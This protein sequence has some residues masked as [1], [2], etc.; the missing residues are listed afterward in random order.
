MPASRPVAAFEPISPDFDVKKLVEST[1]S[2]DYVPRVNVDMLNARGASDFERLVRQHVILGGKP[3]VVEGYES[4]LDRWTFALQWLRDNHSARVETARDLTKK[5]NVPLSIGHY[6]NHMAL[7]TNQWNDKNYKEPARQR[8][9][10]KDI[11]CPPL[12]QEKLQDII[13]PNVFYLNESIGDFGGLGSL[14]EA[15]PSG[16]GTRKGRGVAKAADLMS[17]LPKEMRAENLMCYIGHEGT[18]TPAHKEMCASLGQN[19]MVETSTGAIEDGKP[20]KPGSSIWFMTESKE[21]EVVSEYWLSKLGHDIEVENH[22][23]QVNAWRAAPFKTWVVEQRVGDL[24]LIPPLAP[25]QVWN[26]GTRTMKVAW[27]RTTVETLELA[28]H[29][30]LPSAR[31]VCRDEQYKNKAII[32]YTLQKYS[33]QIRI[34]DKQAQK[35]LRRNLASDAYVQNLKNDFRKLQVLFTEILVSESFYSAN[36]MNIPKPQLIPYESFITCSYCR[37]NIFNRF[38]T[39]P[40][41]IAPLPDGEEDTYDICMD[42]YAMGR[43]CAC[44]SKLKW[45]EQWS[46]GELTQNHEKWR[47]HIL[48]IEGKVSEKSPKSLRTELEVLGRHRTLAQVCQSELAHRP[49]NDIKREKVS[50]NLRKGETDEPEIDDNGIV[51]KSKKPRKSE[52]FVREHARC[53]VDCH[54]E[55][56]WKQAECSNCD[57]KY[58]FGLLFRGYDMMPQDILADPA[59]TCP[60]CRNICSCRNCR[61]RPGF[62]PYTPSGTM[63]GHNT[64]AIADPRS[65]ESLVDFGYSNIS[66][67]QKAGD[68]NE[69]DTRRMRK[70]K[71]IADDRANQQD[72]EVDDGYEQVEEDGIDN[73]IL[74]LAQQEGIPIDPALAAMS[75]GQ[76]NTTFNH[77][78]LPAASQADSDEFDENPEQVRGTD[79]GFGDPPA[80]QYVIPSGGVVRDLEHAYDNIEAI[81]YDYPDPEMGMHPPAPMEP[82]AAETGVAPGYEPAIRGNDGDIAMIERKRKRT[83]VDEGDLTF[84]YKP[85]PQKKK[86]PAKRKSLIVKLNVDK[87]KLAEVQSIQDIAQQALNGVAAVEAPVLSSD[88]QALNTYGSAAEGQSQRKKP[89]LEEPESEEDE[90]T[91]GRYRD[92]RKTIPEGAA[93]HGPDAD[94]TRRQTRMQV[95][96]YEE[97]ADDDVFDDR[98]YE[99]PNGMVGSKL[100]TMEQAEQEVHAIT[101]DDD[102][103][104]HISPPAKP[105]IVSM[106]GDTDPMDLDS[107]E[108]EMPEIPPEVLSEVRAPARPVASSLPKA[109]LSNG[110]HNAPRNGVHV[111]GQSRNTLVQTPAA[112]KPLPKA[113]PSPAEVQ[114]K[115]NQKAKM[116]AMEWAENDG[117]EMEYESEGETVPQ[118]RPVQIVSRNAKSMTNDSMPSETE[119]E[120]ESVPQKENLQAVPSR[121]RLA[122]ERD[123]RPASVES[124][125]QGQAED[126]STG[127]D[128]AISQL[129]ASFAADISQMKTASRRETL[130]A[131]SSTPIVIQRQRQPTP[132]SAPAP[133]AKPSILTK[134]TG[135][136]APPLKKIALPKVSA[137]V[138]GESDSD[139]DGGRPVAKA[140]FTAV[141]KK[142]GAGAGLK[143]VGKG[144]G[145]A[146]AAARPRGRPPKSILYAGRRS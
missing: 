38:L 18:Y 20:T 73:N 66:W 62:K 75:S 116:A 91:P 128:D 120:E 138:W 37:C 35:Q 55:P 54:W 57:K 19:I 49:F 102:T 17:S 72:A 16:S 5:V 93:R 125:R 25:H 87:T 121:S 26:R 142:T 134:A 65:V 50:V 23:A 82:I 76:T 94:I 114:A 4:M 59:W 44:I 32:Y 67:I 33:K 103:A 34:A 61:D 83:K 29:D 141:N 56:K 11:D 115:A 81:T 111:N 118:R 74:M 110:S 113:G 144:A 135:A 130:P 143:P 24:I 10:L 13:L 80:P 136:A 43:S 58:C 63:L 22:F 2:F 101:D 53:H 71:A 88:L 36:V 92:R 70:K 28:L 105:T 117:S 46:W 132:K 68:D 6:L 27:N 95:T 60:S 98:V 45:V 112:A 21:R 89:R 137:S 97:P 119:S 108:V 140:G 96:N 8:M 145:A 7:L 104:S 40:S 127:T 129:Q 78:Q 123:T 100:A 131:A 52:K 122:P 146:V 15:A 9:Y 42:C 109:T 48:Q 99:A 139:S 12:W 3:L 133:Q 77:Q 14:E 41:C 86:T 124:S 85:T 31:M 107:I 69:D 30:A 47:H 79:E 1:D 39:C 126:D 64:K 84:G 106:I 90:F 51:K